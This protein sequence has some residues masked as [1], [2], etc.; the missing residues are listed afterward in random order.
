MITYSN[1][2]VISIESKVAYVISPPR[3][4][5][6]SELS[7]E[8]WLYVAW[9]KAPIKADIL[10]KWIHSRNGQNWKLFYQKSNDQNENI[11]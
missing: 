11:N 5:S 8:P 10:K 1:G 7:E 4:H 2:Y 6:N 9:S 3:L